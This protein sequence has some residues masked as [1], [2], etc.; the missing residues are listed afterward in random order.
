[1]HC[2]LDTSLPDWI[3]DYPETTRIFSELGMDC[4]CA[5]KSLQYVCHQHGLNPADILQR[6]KQAVANSESHSS[7]GPRST[8]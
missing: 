6:L 3:I 4:S 2:D 5:G 1:M 7:L 8:P